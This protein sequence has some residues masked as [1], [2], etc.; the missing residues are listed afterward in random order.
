MEGRI[1]GGDVAKVGQFPWHVAIRTR[2]L[3][4]ERGICGG[5]L[6]EREWVLTAAHC[7][8]G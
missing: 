6:I 7:M 1:L 3:K 4:K 5:A 2:N 8:D